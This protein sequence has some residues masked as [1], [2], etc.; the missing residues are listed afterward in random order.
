MEVAILHVI[1]ALVSIKISPIGP[2]V[3]K[4]QT[5]Q[6]T[7]TG[8]FSDDSTQNL[9]GQVTWSL[10]SPSVASISNAT[11]TKGLASALAIGRPRR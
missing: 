10:S 4:G 3:H 2:S 11:G 1:P 7:A 6:F 5:A 9:T 8:T